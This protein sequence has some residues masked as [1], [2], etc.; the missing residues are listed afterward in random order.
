MIE[1]VLDKP[2]CKQLDILPVSMCNLWIAAEKLGA[3]HPCENMS[4][5]TI[6]TMC[7]VQLAIIDTHKNVKLFF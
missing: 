1:K 6:V 7:R 2:N 5:I 3:A 4:K